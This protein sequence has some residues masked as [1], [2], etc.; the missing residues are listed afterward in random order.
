MLKFSRVRVNPVVLPLFLEKR[1][2]RWVRI[3]RRVSIK[4]RG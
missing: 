1:T 4:K 3:I 2:S